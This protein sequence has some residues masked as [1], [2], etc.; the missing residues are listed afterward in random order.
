MHQNVA[1]CGNG[2]NCIKHEP[3]KIY[4]NI[5]SNGEIPFNEQNF[6]FCHCS[7]YGPLS[8]DQ[9]HIV[10]PLSVCLSVHPSPFLTMFS[11]L[12]GTYF[13]ILNAL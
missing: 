5:E 12:Y 6:I 1:L 10:L 2:L 3:Y 4:E 13:V 9:E 11:I 8:K 7:F